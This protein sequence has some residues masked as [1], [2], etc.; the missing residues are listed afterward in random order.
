MKTL[1][2]FFAVVAVFFAVAFFAVGCASTGSVVSLKNSVDNELGKLISVTKDVKGKVAATDEELKKTNVNL[3]TF[4]LR[5]DD[6]VRRVATTEGN[7]A[8]LN[9]GIKLAINKGE[10]AGNLAKEN[11]ELAKAALKKGEAAEKKGDEAIKIARGEYTPEQSAQV[12][13]ELGSSNPGH[14]H[15]SSGASHGVKINSDIARAEATTE[16]PLRRGSAEIPLNMKVSVIAFL[17]GDEGKGLK[18]MTV[19]GVEDRVPPKA[20]SPKEAKKINAEL[21]EERAEAAKT[22]FSKWISA[23]PTSWTMP[24][25]Q[26]QNLKNFPG[27]IILLLRKDKP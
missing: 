8:N 5:L 20:D 16:I 21:A 2:R 12:R 23:S 9:N 14:G 18:I 6:I 25:P 19:I 26:S 7:I 27:G 1:S 3:A 17:E 10:E 22:A 13:Q 24:A 4:G 11:N 15:A